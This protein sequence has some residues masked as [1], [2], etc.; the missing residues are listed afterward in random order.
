MFELQPVLLPVRPSLL[1]T[2]LKMLILIVLPEYD[3]IQTTLTEIQNG[4]LQIPDEIG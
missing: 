2:I 4:T 3:I 1:G